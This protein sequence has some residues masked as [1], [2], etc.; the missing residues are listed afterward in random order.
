LII[1]HSMTASLLAARVASVDWERAHADL[2]TQGW[3]RLPALLTAPE[4]AALAAGYSQERLYRSTI[5]MERY[6]FGRGEYRYFAYPLPP[7]VQGLRAA[8]YPRL[9]PVA[10]AWWQRLRRQDAFPPALSAFLEQ[11]HA[12]GQTRP[13]P[14][15]LRYRPGDYNCLHQ[16]IYGEIAF[17]LQVSIML[18]A[19][20]RDYEGGEIVLV[21]QRPRAQS[22]AT[23]LALD[24]GDGLVFT[25]RE[26]PARGSRGWY[27][28]QMRHG[29][30][31]LASGERF[32]LGVIFHDAK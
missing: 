27:A 14:L 17:P 10:N 11:C 5:D 13:T 18:S 28:V 21:E 26:R 15:I 3:A 16:D 19:R 4:C 8:L 1:D 9:Q 22:K 20:G 7:A 12:A 2:D 29:V 23:A 25:N 24:R 31:P 32:V 30:S 6:R